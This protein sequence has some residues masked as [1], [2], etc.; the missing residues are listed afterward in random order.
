MQIIMCEL[1]VAKKELV[2]YLLV[3]SFNKYLENAFYV[4]A[5]FICQ[6]FQAAEKIKLKI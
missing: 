5:L 1:W 2:I 3:H 6:T 4:R